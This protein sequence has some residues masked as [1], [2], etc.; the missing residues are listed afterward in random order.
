MAYKDLVIRLSQEEKHQFVALA[1][2][3]DKPVASNSFELRF[4]E[5]RIIERLRELE[6]AAVKPESQVTFHKSFG[7][8]TLLERSWRGSSATTSRD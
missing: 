7:Q 6:K 3:G 2:E 5:L 4:D 8:E 1:L